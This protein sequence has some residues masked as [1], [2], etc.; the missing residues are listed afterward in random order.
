MRSVEDKKTSV[1]GEKKQIWR[2][3][4]VVYKM[5]YRGNNLNRLRK[6]QSI[7]QDRRQSGHNSNLGHPDRDLWLRE[8]PAGFWQ[9]NL[10]TDVHLHL[11]VRQVCCE[12]RRWI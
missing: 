8:M 2:T 10:M 3:W 5:Y 12:D 7:G 4:V 11:I 9:G 1:N 6:T